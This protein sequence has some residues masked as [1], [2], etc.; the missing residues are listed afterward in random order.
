MQRSQEG[1]YD[2]TEAN[3]ITADANLETIPKLAQS[4][5]GRMLSRIGIVSKR[6]SDKATDVCTIQLHRFAQVYSTELHATS[7]HC[8]VRLAAQSRAFEL[9]YQALS[10]SGWQDW[11]S[12]VSLPSL[13]LLDGIIT[14]LEKLFYVWS[15]F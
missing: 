2:T 10:K 8:I 9:Q 11:L 14:A 3:H 6:S 13:D 5:F 7:D 15:C 12:S 1:L 4:E